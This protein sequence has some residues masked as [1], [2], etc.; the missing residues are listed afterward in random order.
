[1]N[2]LF[3]SF[4]LGGLLQLVYWPFAENYGSII[5]FAALEGLTGSWFMV[6]CSRFRF[7]APSPL[8][9]F[10][11]FFVIAVTSIAVTLLF[12][13]PSQSLIPV[14]AA[15]LFGLEGLATIVGFSVLVNSPG[16]MLG[17]TLSGFV[18]SGSGGSYTAVA[19]YSGG[20]MCGGSLLILYG[21][22][23]SW[24]KS[25]SSLETDLLPSSSLLQP[26]Q[27]IRQIL[28]IVYGNVQHLAEVAQAERTTRRLAAGFGPSRKAHGR[29]RFNKDVVMMFRVSMLPSPQ[30]KP[31]QR[32]S[33]HS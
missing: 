11:S 14:A 16:Q 2:T 33:S 4:F 18:L 10:A 22:S 1:V 13:Q 24:S 30:T 20:M 25:L 29:A 26:T 23:S 32:S 17:A 21:E 15:Q 3:L 27:A 19:C 6:R 12:N 8:L 28:I 7:S 5:G 9:T 31:W